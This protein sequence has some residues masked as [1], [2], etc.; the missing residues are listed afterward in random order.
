M[1]GE[2]KKVKSW[3]IFLPVL[4]GLLAVAYMFNEEFEPSAF[5]E[6][7][8]T[9]FSVFWLVMAVFCIVGRDLGYIVRI[10]G[11]SENQLTWRQAFR[12]IMLWEFT[13]A[14]TPSSI[15]GTSV[16]L[17]YVH[18]EG[19]SI[20]KSSAMVMMTSLLDELYF[21]VMFPIL[22]F[23]IGLTDLFDIEDSPGWTHG[24]LWLAMIGYIIKF[25]W[26]MALIYGM[27]VNPKGLGKM[28]FM[29]FKLPFL[30]RWKRGAVKALRE[31]ELSSTELKFKKKSFW[32][33]AF[34]TTF[35]SWTSRYW[36]VNCLFMAFFA[37]H[38]HFLI[39]ARQLVMWVAM[40]LSP[41]PGGSGVA[42]IMFSRYLG[43]FIPLAGFAVALALLWRLVTYY[44]YLIIG[45]FVVPRWISDNFI[46][47]KKKRNEL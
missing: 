38:D 39:F 37:V 3:K 16:A 20:G 24:M 23:S 28:I 42:E 11:L 26:V 34:V 21:V 7:D 35:V 31:I 1:N 15:G 30:K 40:L 32:I 8:F 2:I 47:K 18:K 13:S 36:I 14:V 43:E 17:M 41:T 44:P 46:S 6:I 29:L 22:A 5:D 19:I 10:R 45:A 9:W 27:F 33:K 25:V 12:V 4:I